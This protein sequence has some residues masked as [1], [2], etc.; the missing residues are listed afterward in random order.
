MSV[1]GKKNCSRPRRRLSRFPLMFPHAV[2]LVCGETTK[3]H[4]VSLWLT[5]YLSGP[6]LRA[7]CHVRPCRPVQAAPTNLYYYGKPEKTRE[8]FIW[9]I[10]WHPFKS[11]QWLWWDHSQRKTRISLNLQHCNPPC[12]M[13]IKC[14]GGTNATSL[15]R[16][17]RNQRSFWSNERKETCLSNI[18]KLNSTDKK[19]N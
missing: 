6:A 7:A 12:L 19:E 11:L 8:C 1:K 17:F 2:F 3:D 15:N 10:K 16:S 5:Y 18:K 14:Q 13:L 4:V 9:H